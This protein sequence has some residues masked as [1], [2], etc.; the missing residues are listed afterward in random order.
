MTFWER[1][2]NPASLGGQFKI[3]NI[4]FRT[5][6]S[7]LEIQQEDEKKVT[8]SRAFTN[9]P[10]IIAQ[11]ETFSIVHSFVRKLVC[12]CKCQG[13]LVRFDVTHNII[14][15]LLCLAIEHWNKHRIK[16]REMWR[17]EKKTSHSENS[18]TNSL[19]MRIEKHLKRCS[20]FLWLTQKNMLNCDLLLRSLAWSDFSVLN[21]DEVAILN[22]FVFPSSL[23]IY[24][25]LRRKKTQHFL[26]FLSVDLHLFRRQWF[27]AYYLQTRFKCWYFSDFASLFFQF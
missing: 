6:K 18:R 21:L 3:N 26:S 13:S 19:S 25:N 17:R 9:L 11:L 27:R 14:T 15:N 5:K 22:S 2:K 8:I 16:R 20:V 4:N 23:S 1:E 10:R 24:F 7:R 12:G